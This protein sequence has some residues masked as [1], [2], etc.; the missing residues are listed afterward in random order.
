MRRR[1]SLRSMLASS[2]GYGKLSTP[3]DFVDF[4]DLFRA[5]ILRTR[6][7]L[8]NLFDQLTSSEMQLNRNM[9]RQ[10]IQ[11]TGATNCTGQ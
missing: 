4:V 2:R 10:Q 8:K 11:K 5:F 1:R 9:P 3:L 7:D 6:K